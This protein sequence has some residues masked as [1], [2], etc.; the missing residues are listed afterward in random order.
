MREESQFYL[1]DITTIFACSF[2]VNGWHHIR[3]TL[4]EYDKNPKI[5]YGETSLYPFLKNFQPH[6]ICEVAQVACKLPLFSYP[7]GGFTREADQSVFK[8]PLKS[9]FCGP[10][11]EEFIEEE[12]LRIIKLY[13]NLKEAGYRPWRYPNSFVGGV[14]L[15]SLEGKRKFVVLQGNHRMAVFSHIGIDPISVRFL[16]GHKKIIFERDI[17]NWTNVSNGMCCREDAK[18]I[19]DMYFNQNGQH[20]KS[21]LNMALNGMTYEK[22]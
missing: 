4:K 2:G 1:Q 9:R 3:E 22:K 18:K 6:S 7:W 5:R 10:S 15:Q 20:I 17:D 11:T 14:I 21:K 19:F 8:D 13:E 16:K 12:F